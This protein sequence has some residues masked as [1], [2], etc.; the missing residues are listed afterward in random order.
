MYFELYSYIVN[1]RNYFYQLCEYPA[2]QTLM[3][4]LYNAQ[5]KLF[6]MSCM[7]LK[8]SSLILNVNPDFYNSHFN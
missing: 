5:T 6:L 7:E 8:A 3:N 1:K 2:G 4:R